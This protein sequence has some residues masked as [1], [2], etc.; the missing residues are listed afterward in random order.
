MNKIINAFLILFGSISIGIGIIGIFIPLLPTAPL[1]LLG[2]A[3]F[4][5][6]SDKLY[7]LLLK[8]KWLGGYIEDF[9]V[10]KG[11]SLKN[12]ILGLTMLW[13]SIG[14]SLVLVITNLWVSL[15][16]VIIAFSVSIWILSYKT[17]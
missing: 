12:K 13:L 8:N 4:V 17:L 10:R 3:C 5:R 2:A 14:S 16:L 1:V 9:R 11:I 6:G 15:I 7:Q